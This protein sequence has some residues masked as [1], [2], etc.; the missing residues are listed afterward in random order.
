MRARDIAGIIPPLASTALYAVGSGLYH[1]LLPLRLKELGYSDSANGLIAV[2]GSGGFLLGCLINARLIRAVGHVRAYAAA[3][4]AIAVTLLA[5]DL[6]PSLPLIA[7]L[8]IAGGI[9]AAALSMVIE[10]WLNEAVEMRYRGQLLTVYMLTLALFW[11]VGQYLC[12]GLAPT[13]SRMLILSAGFITLALIPVTAV[14]VASPTPPR[15]V[16]FNPLSA[17]KI[18]PTGMLSCL[19]T[20]LVSATFAYIGP[21]YGAARGL[22]QTEIILLMMTA[23]A[24][25]LALQ[26]PLGYLSD[27]FG[28]SRVLAGM[29]AASALVASTI[30][31]LGAAP[32]LPILAVLFALFGGL[33]ESFYP[34][35]V[36]YAND[37][38]APDD[39]VALSSNLLFI[40]SLGAMIGPA[41][42]T[43]AL[44]MAGP[45]SFFWYVL[46]LA[47]SLGLFIVARVLGRWR[48][49]ILRQQEFQPLPPTTSAVFEWMPPADA[50]KLE[51]QPPNES[52]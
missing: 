51:Q 11:A 25:G 29:A 17:L 16:R 9:A 7:V 13:G 46:I 43:T 1:T 31:A 28:R 8:Q 45:T 5:L 39:Y 20:G 21:L 41:V 19:F 10:S 47:V 14:Q 40:W 22:A 26:W 24:G 38:A 4:A 36:A 48:H 52:S 49:K 32:P 23:Q 50:A 37:R 3:A 2:C 42:T 27:N 6:L 35:G 30:L 44:Q 34:I 18:S 33:A 12:I 15:S